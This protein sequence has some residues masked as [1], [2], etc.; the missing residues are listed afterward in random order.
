MHG[1]VIIQRCH[2]SHPLVDV[3]AV[4]TYKQH[5][6]RGD[7]G[8]DDLQGKVAFNGGSVGAVATAT[9]EAHQAEDQ[10]P[11]DS[12]EKNR[13]DAEQHLEQGVVNRGVAAGVDGQ[14][15]DVVTHPQ[16]G[17]HKC[18]AQQEGDQG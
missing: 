15:G 13:A 18:H 12:E 3:V 17:K 9:A 4:D 14:H 1:T 2:A 6:H 5:H 11:H 16:S 10:H 8:P 7:G